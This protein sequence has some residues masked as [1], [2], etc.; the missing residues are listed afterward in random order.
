MSLK[1]IA[2]LKI[3]VVG[4]VSLE[5]PVLSVPT[6]TLRVTLSSGRRDL[7]VPLSWE[8]RF[9]LYDVRYF[10]SYIVL[11]LRIKHLQVYVQLQQ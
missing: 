6:G 11:M 2:W 3:K 8:F 5:F 1:W 7:R 9:V 4:V 10:V